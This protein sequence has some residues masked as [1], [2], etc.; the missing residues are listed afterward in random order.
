M[1]NRL[2]DRLHDE[3]GIALVL[4]LMTMTVLTIVA[5]TTIYY[6]TSSEHTSSR[7]KAADSAY[8]LAESGINNAMATLGYSQTN[9]LS[10]TALPNSESVATSQS[11]ATGTAKWWGTLN[12]DT[13]MWTIYGK[14][15]VQSPIAN[16]AT[17]TRTLSATMQ[18]TYSYQQPVN[19]QAW[20]YVYLTAK[21]GA[22]TCDFLLDNNVEFD[23]PL[24]MEGNL[25]LN[26]NATIRE[27][28][29]SP[30]IPV[31]II[32][33]GKVAFANGTSV[34]IS[35]TNTVS[36]AYIVGGCGTTL[37]NVHTCVPAPT[38]GHDP[39]YV[40]GGGFSTVAPA[41]DPPSVDWV[42]DGW[43]ANASPGP[44][45]GCTTTSGTPPVFDG[46]PAPNDTQQN[47][48]APYA[49]GS[50]GT[51][52]LTPAASYTCKTT[53]GELSW[54]AT[55]H[56]ITINGVIY[57]D[58]NVTIGDGAVD[59]YNGQATMY[60]SG[61]ATIGGTMCGKR[62]A[63]NTDCDF[64]AWDPNTEM[65]ILAAHGD[66]GSGN[67][68][69][70][71]DSTGDRWEG[72]IYATNAIGVANN[73]TIEGPIIAGTFKTNNNFVVEP[74]PVITSV[75]LGAPGNP[76]VYAQPNPPGGYSG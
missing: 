8:R 22:N 1:L 38:S 23:A 19:T 31:S 5:G 40:A 53:A 60:V 39:L 49:N 76:N 73:G 65:W 28:L 52:N 13:K 11:Y 61:Y 55:T 47:L 29:A 3:R 51:V 37:S 45:H 7:S 70:L 2:R 69:V 26:N 12:S 9:A 34:G 66:D 46:G 27:D 10:P 14:G 43:Y 42:N 25:C 71:P 50:G 24:Y 64:S 72:G 16:T 30:K 48:T 62:N 18:V 68:V 56:T 21:G 63:T 33:K 54:N 4:A 35:T 75:P 6:S 15:F 36:S 20:N 67:S 17:V 74:F 59:E 58:G 57:I 41:I 32:V 44:L